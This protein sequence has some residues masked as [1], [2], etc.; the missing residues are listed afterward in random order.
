M[1]RWTDNLDAERIISEWHGA[2]WIRIHQESG[3]R[4]TDRAD[5]AVLVGLHNNK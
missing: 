5:G 4:K 3:G 2:E 1:S